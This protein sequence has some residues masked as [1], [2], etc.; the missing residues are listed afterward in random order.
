MR[1]SKPSFLEISAFAPTIENSEQFQRRMDNKRKRDLE[2]IKQLNKIRHSNLSV[3]ETDPAVLYHGIGFFGGGTASVFS[4][5]A[6]PSQYAMIPLTSGFAFFVLGSAYFTY[7]AF[8]R[9]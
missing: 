8:K 3:P 2:Q 7:Q 9:R 4:I 1:T 6:T 5:F